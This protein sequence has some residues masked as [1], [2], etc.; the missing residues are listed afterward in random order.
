MATI[1]NMSLSYTYAVNGM[2]DMQLDIVDSDTEVSDVFNYMGSF[3][4]TNENE[5]DTAQILLNVVF[6]NDNITLSILGVHEYSSDVEELIRNETLCET[7]D[8]C[9]NLLLFLN[10]F[11]RRVEER[12]RFLKR[13]LKRG[14]I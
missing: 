7:V 9:N 12:K 13:E 10:E 5:G 6:E 4:E 3:K 8:D 1:V 11:K 2:K 14:N